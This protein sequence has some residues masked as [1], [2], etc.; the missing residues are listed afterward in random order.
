MPVQ[1]LP[2]ANYNATTG[3]FVQLHPTLRDV[4][5]IIYSYAAFELVMADD[6]SAAA[7]ESTANRKMLLASTREVRLKLDL[8][9][10]W[11]RG[12]TASA[13]ELFIIRQD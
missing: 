4:D 9:R 13:A 3:A 10:T 1:I 2:R 11:V 8:Q 5:C 6:S 12:A 7:A